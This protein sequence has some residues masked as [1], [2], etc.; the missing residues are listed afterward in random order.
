[1]FNNVKSQLKKVIVIFL[2]I[3]LSYANI[4]LIGNNIIQGLFSYALEDGQESIDTSNEEVSSDEENENNS[5]AILEEEEM[6]LLNIENKDI[7]KTTISE[8]G[9]V[10]YTE[11]IKVNLDYITETFDVT[12]EDTLSEFYNS[13][14]TLN[15]EIV[16]EYKTTTINKSDLISFLGDEGK[17]II[18]DALTEKILVELTKTGLISQ[19]LDLKVEQKFANEESVEEIRSNVTVKEE[20]VE[21]EYVAKF[22]NIKIEIENITIEKNETQSQEENEEE[23]ETEE[24]IIKNIKSI[25]NIEEVENLDYLKSSV[26]YIIN[27]DIENEKTIDSIIKFKD[28]I[29][30]ADLTVDNTEWIVGEANTVNYTITLDTTSEK[31]ELFVNPMFLIE[32]P[33]SVATIN[34][35]NSEFTVNNDDGVFTNKK[36]FTTTVLGKK[37]VVITLTGEQTSESI[38]NGNTTIDLTLELNIS[39]DETEGSKITKLYYQNDTVT[40]YENG[41]SF[42]TDEI[43]ISL[44]LNNEPK[45]EIKESIEI[46]IQARMISS[47]E[48]VVKT[49]EEIKYKIYLENNK[50]AE[51]QNIQVI[52]ALPEGVE[53]KKVVEIV[54]GNVSQ[55]V[56][57][58]YNEETR[59]L[60]VDLD[61]IESAIEKQASERTASTVKA[62]SR[63]LEIAVQAKTLEDG[64]YS[65]EIKNLAK[66]IFDEKEVETNEVTNTISDVFIE[67]ETQENEISINEKD[68]IV[69]EVKIINKGLIDVY[70]LDCV[71]NFPESIELVMAEYGIAGEEGSISTASGNKYEQSLIDIPAEKTYYIRLT[72]ETGEVDETK[73]ITVTGTVAEKDFSWTTEIVNVPEKP[74]NPEDPENPNDPSD[75]ENPS[76]PE[77]PNNPEDPE[78]PSNPDE[79][80]NPENPSNPNEPGNPNDPEN[81]NIPD[82]KTD[83]FDL[84]LKQYLNKVIVTNS[85][86]TTTY[87][88]TNTD[89][90]K[91]EIH[92]KQMNGS[93]VTLEYK[94][95]VK[96]EGTIPGYARK[97]VNYISK[98]LTFNSDLNK[99]WFVG[100]DG[101]LY[102]IALI[103][104]LLNPGETAELTIVLE[105]QMTNENIG[106]ITNIVEIY[107]A[108]ADDNAEDINSIPG[109]KL[110]GQNDMSTVQVMIVVKTGTII[111][112]ITL[113]ITVIA[114]LG[115][116]FYKVKKVTLKK[117]GC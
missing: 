97:I 2:I 60:I 38:Q 54:E 65:K 117:G 13:D 3:T 47:K 12:I 51:V 25:S 52:D 14:K 105:K 58:I 40:T 90:A 94:I 86:G 28:T 21:I 93:K 46:P 49:L 33:S 101:N 42:D 63:I 96:N 107:E 50:T 110:E 16:L 43:E 81:P 32:L 41:S 114:I 48:N 91:V 100:N 67:I 34:T 115:V 76:D 57:Y 72:G 61:K 78:N 39:E 6:Q 44:I 62:G 95:I 53:F 1:M 106:T 116:G 64:I 88:Y 20:T 10:E 108:T 5:E 84:S 82:N 104:R 9:T 89:F 80:N 109:D 26:K 83:E 77:D 11:N 30:R 98:D 23:I 111:L 29:T 79:P 8:D 19:E 70:Q 69:F 31:S 68:Q 15:E 112:Y 74:N 71:V 55:E 66:V 36:V 73:D 75:P 45:E 24:F 27:D 4:A 59:E 92:A 113:A 102:S 35:A 17:I 37:Y 103:D 18:K 87:D 22:T 56:D 85:Q 99:E 7:H